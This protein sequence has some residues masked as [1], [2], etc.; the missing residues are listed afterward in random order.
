MQQ[1]G[2]HVGMTGSTC[3]VMMHAHLDMQALDL[4]SSAQSPRFLPLCGLGFWAASETL[5]PKAVSVLCAV[6]FSCVELHAVLPRRITALPAWFRV[7]Y[8]STLMI[9]SS[10]GSLQMSSR[11]PMKSRSRGKLA[12]TSSSSQPRR[13]LRTTARRCIISACTNIVGNICL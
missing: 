10:R 11:L 9:F 5:A 4:F 3:L 8:W 6:L 7:R 13:Y 1:R 2:K 12:A